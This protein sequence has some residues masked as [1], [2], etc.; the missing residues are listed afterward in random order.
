MKAE[1]DGFSSDEVAAQLSRILATDGFRRSPSLGRFLTYLVD[2]ALAGEHLSIKEYR[3]GLDVFDRG[4]DFDPRDDTIVRVQARNLRARLDGYYKNPAAIDTIRFVLPKGAYALRFE[5]IEKPAVVFTEPAAQARSG[6]RV[7]LTGA[8]LIGISVVG[9]FAARHFSASTQ[10]SAPGIISLVVTPFSSLSADRDNQYFAGGLTEEV[11]D[12]L[13]N[14]AGLRVVARTFSVKW[15]DQELNFANLRELE[16][17]DVVEGSVRKEGSK[18]RISVRLI[19]LANGSQLWSHE[20]DREVRDSITT[21]QEIASAVAATLKLKFAPA[22]SA[23]AINPPNSDAYELYLKGRYSWQQ[24]DAAGADRGIAYL[25]RSLS[26]DPSFAPAYVALAGCYATQVVYYRIP[27]VEGYA[28]DREMALS[29]LELD[30]TVAEAHTMLAGVYAWN[31]WNWE[32]SELEFHAG[33]QLGPQSVIAHQYYASFLGALGRRSEAETLM[34]E[35][36]HLDP[37]DSLLQWGE[38]QLMLWRGD[39]RKSEEVLMRVMKRDPEFGLTAKLLAEVE[40]TLGKDQ[41]AE[42]VLR[43]HLA[44]HPSD[45]IPLGE[46]GY[47]LGKTGRSQEARDIL[48]QLDD[49]TRQSIVPRQALAFVYQGLGDSDKAIDE[50]WKASD[51]RTLRVPW[52]RV[53]PVYAPLRRNPRWPDLL[54][55]VNLQQP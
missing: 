40:W 2:R 39:V 52:L 6:W 45:P 20:Y 29:A 21:E 42:Q 47:T 17:D 8:S 27:A 16:I 11:T 7:W 54:R 51:A 3:L 26:L 33:V 48:R 50:L 34:H 15:K 55:H 9:V 46:L 30:G 24:V 22:A 13:A 35:A 10:A 41:E 23:K 1:I 49:K 14:L 5:S 36:I 37:L 32:R 12:A 53:E 28:K 18:V 44:K 25:Q 31:D 38:A 19:N 43:A 4:E